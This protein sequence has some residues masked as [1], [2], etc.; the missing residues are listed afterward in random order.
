MTVVCATCQRYL[1]TKPPY[2]DVGVTHGTCTS[3]AIRQRRELSTLVVSRER[4]DAWPVLESV[5][6]AH[7]DVRLVLERRNGDRRQISLDVDT[8]RR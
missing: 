4:A 3:C 7:N 2:G 5:F 8:C 1:G 6:R